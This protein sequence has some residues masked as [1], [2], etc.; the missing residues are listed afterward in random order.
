MSIA[1]CLHKFYQQYSGNNEQ[2]TVEGGTVKECL[3]NLTAVY[4][5]LG[6][7]LYTGNE[8]LHPLVGIYVN[9]T[10]IS[11]DGMDKEVKDGDKIHLIHTLAGG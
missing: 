5:E 11:Y 1:I 2:V 4:P 8:K 7:A 10:V 9:S 3:E 6:K